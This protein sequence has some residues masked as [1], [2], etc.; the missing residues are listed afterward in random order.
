MNRKYSVEELNSAIDV[1]LEYLLPKQNIKTQEKDSII[2]IMNDLQNNDGSEF[3]HY[4]PYSLIFKITSGCNLRCKHCFFQE[5]NASYLTDKDLSEDE[6]FEYLKFFVEEVNIVYC[7]LT[8]GEVFTTPYLMRFVEYLKSKNIFVEL[9]SNGTIIKP[10]DAKKLSELLNPK[11]DSVQISLEGPEAVNDLIRG[12]GVFQKAVQSIKL[13]TSNNI[14]VF[15]SMTV[16]SLNVDKIEEMYDIC[17]EL[18]VK[19]LNIGRMVIC[20][21]MQKD[22]YPDNDDIIINLAK[23]IEKSK[24]YRDTKIKIRALKTFDLIMYEHAKNYLDEIIEKEKP[25]LEETNFHCRSKSGQVALF[26]DGNIS[27]C[28]DCDKEEMFIGNIKKQSFYEIWKNRKDRLMFR[29]RPLDTTCKKCKYIALCKGGCPINAYNKYGT[30]NAPDGNCKYAD[31]MLSE[32]V[33]KLEGTKC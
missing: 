33:W 30:I 7:S 27:L 16:N 19:R 6:L 5:N 10:E 28:Y 31:K 20:N 22:L 17:R 24:K 1:C 8:G 15:V 2:D 12:K 23:T 9:L 21:D 18:K 3:T 14:N 11:T 29:K 4:L 26:P 32:H 13:L 25:K